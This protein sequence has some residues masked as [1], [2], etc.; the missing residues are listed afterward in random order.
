M[1]TV[2]NE[3]QIDT[4]KLEHSVI[5]AHAWDGFT[6]TTADGHP[7]TLAVVDD[8]GRIVEIGP[9]LVAELWDVAVLSYR[10]FLIGEKAL[11]VCSTPAGLFQE[12][13]DP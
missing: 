6:I 2:A 13:N 5:R 12:C 3:E 7:A 8:A 10:R 11:T 4:A 9:T 1:E